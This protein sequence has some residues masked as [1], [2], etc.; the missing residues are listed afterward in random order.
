MV[1]SNMLTFDAP[2]AQLSDAGNIQT[3][4]I[5]ESIIEHVASFLGAENSEKIKEMNLYQNGQV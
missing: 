5:M 1:H 4:F 2:D 3:M